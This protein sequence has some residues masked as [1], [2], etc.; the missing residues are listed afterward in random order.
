VIAALE[1]VGGGTD[2]GNPFGLEEKIHEIL[3][4]LTPEI[5][6]KTEKNILILL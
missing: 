5:T 1:G 2:Y 3:H 4:L 6:E